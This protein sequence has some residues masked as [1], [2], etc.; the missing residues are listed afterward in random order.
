MNIFRYSAAVNQP[1]AK[2][3]KHQFAQS[4][5]LM[6]YRARAL[7]SFIP[8]NAC[9]TLRL[10]LAIENGCI[11]GEQ[12]INWIHAN[13]GT[14]QATLQDAITA[15]Y[16]FVV[17]RCP[18][19]RLAS[20]FLDKFVSKDVPSWQYVEAMGR[21][22]SLDELTFAD[23]TRSLLRPAIR[24]ANIH[25]RP[26]VDFLLF[27]QYH[28]VFSVERFSQAVTKL[29]DVLGF[30]VR[31]ARS[32]TRHGLDQFQLVE[33]GG[34]STVPVRELAIMKAEGCLPSV[35]TLYDQATYQAV[36]KAY[37]NDIELYREF[38]IPDDLLTA[39]EVS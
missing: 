13:N 7:Y 5:A 39:G 29:N 16:S 37:R 22:V 33:S 11:R 20:V 24:N 12:D 35:A 28:D 27:D 21:E 32:L 30:K 14:F 38:C 25:W 8:K 23:F 18:F 4:H 2:N 6:L 31:D 9:S 1:L 17:L 3:G 36:A 10:S 15:D 34:F 26:Q 19:R